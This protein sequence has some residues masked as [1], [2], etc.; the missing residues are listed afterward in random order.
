MMKLRLVYLTQTV[1]VKLGNAAES[2]TTAH[3]CPREWAWALSTEGKANLEELILCIRRGWGHS[4]CLPTLLS[5]LRTVQCCLWPLR[6]SPG[7]KDPSNCLIWGQYL[8]EPC[9]LLWLHVDICALAQGLG[10]SALKECSAEW[11]VLIGWSSSNPEQKDHFTQFPRINSL[12]VCTW[13][14]R[15]FCEV[16]A[17]ASRVWF[18][19]ST[20]KSKMCS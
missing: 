3:S 20:G 9:L 13:I 2:W 11:K 6:H 1:A 14:P 15:L 18:S 19:S 5:I 10:C 17:H 7:S 16:P 8:T 4:R 12:D